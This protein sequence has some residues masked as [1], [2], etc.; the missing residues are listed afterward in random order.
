METNEERGGPTAIPFPASV[1]F[2]SLCFSLSARF[3]RIP[4]KI[5][6]E[7]RTGKGETRVKPFPVLFYSSSSFFVFFVSF[8]VPHNATVAIR[9][10]TRK[11]R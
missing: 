5:L 6:S 10:M 7:A 1:S 11:R 2:T 9:F 8:V 4:Q 3:A